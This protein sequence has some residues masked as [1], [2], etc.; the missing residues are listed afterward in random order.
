MKTSLL[1]KEYRWKL[2]KKL[3]EMLYAFHNAL[4]IDNRV[5]AFFIKSTHFHTPFYFLLLYMLLP[6][7]LA[8]LALLPLIGCFMLYLYLD[9]CFLTKLENK[10]DPE[11]DINIIDPYI[12][13]FGI[14]LTPKNRG[15]YTL[16]IC[17]VYFTF[18]FMLLMMRYL[19]KL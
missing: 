5:Q 13:P 7:K 9:G 12:A 8:I 17:G 1:D 3:V 15:V 16:I 4:P 19:L 10:L 18:V 6:L 11:Y 2:K 14:E